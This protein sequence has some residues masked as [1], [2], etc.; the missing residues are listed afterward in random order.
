MDAWLTPSEQ[1]TST[2]EVVLR[3][4]DTPH[5]RAVLRGVL[6]ALT[7]EE[8]WEPVGITREQAAAEWRTAFEDFLNGR[9]C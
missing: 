1:A 8:S 6:F 3:I 4:P 2:V 7:R 9:T 5:Q